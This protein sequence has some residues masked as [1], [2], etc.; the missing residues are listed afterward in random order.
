MRKTC[1]I[2]VYE[3]GNALAPWVTTGEI[4]FDDSR[5]A[6]SYRDGEDRYNYAGEQVG[7]GHWV[8]HSSNPGEQETLSLHTLPKTFIYEGYW[9]SKMPTQ[10]GFWRIFID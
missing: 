8:L 1:R 6:V 4:V 9:E 2:E 5:I 10:S 3:T 7:I